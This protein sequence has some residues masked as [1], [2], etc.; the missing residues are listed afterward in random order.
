M[1]PKDI[2]RFNSKIDKSGDCWDWTAS[3]NGNGYGNFKL[4]GKSPNKLPRN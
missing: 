1:T 2:E 4:N 3:D